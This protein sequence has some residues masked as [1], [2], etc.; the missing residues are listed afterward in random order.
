MITIN[1]S[2]QRVQRISTRCCNCIRKLQQLFARGQCIRELQ[3]RIATQQCSREPQ[4]IPA[5]GTYTGA[6]PQKVYEKLP[7]HSRRRGACLPGPLK[8]CD[9]CGNPYPRNTILQKLSCGESVAIVTNALR[10]KRWRYRSVMVTLQA[11]MQC[12]L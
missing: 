7:L 4:P 5:V 2:E 10:L 9:T 1:A 8:P 12:S 3:Q 6:L 11:A